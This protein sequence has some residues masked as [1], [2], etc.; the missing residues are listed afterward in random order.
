VTKSKAHI[1]EELTETEQLSGTK[2]Q[3][4]VDVLRHPLAVT[5]NRHREWMDT[6]VR[7]WTDDAW[8]KCVG[9]PHKN[10]KIRKACPK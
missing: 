3:S 5:G 9:D 2:L 8:R 7:H 6:D 4:D 1:I 10:R